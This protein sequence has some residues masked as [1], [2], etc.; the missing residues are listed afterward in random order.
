[1][2]LD[3]EDV[4]L[5]LQRRYNVLRDIGK[6]TEDL[7]E[8]VAREDQVSVSLLLEMRADEMVKYDAC[9]EQILLLAEAGAEEALLIRELVLSRPF[10]ARPPAGPEEQSIDEICGRTAALLEQIREKD[11]ILNRRVSGDKSFYGRNG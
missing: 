9:Q 10:P 4:L 3:L 5:R 1:M 8:A 6:Q 7:M 11:R 2:K